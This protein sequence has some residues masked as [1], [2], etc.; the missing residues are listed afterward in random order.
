MGAVQNHFP[1]EFL[2]RLDETIIFNPLSRADMVSVV[3]IRLKELEARLKANKK[4]RLDV[5]AEAKDWLASAG[6][7]PQYGARPLN[8]VIQSEILFPLSRCVLDG[9]VR[10]TETAVIEADHVNNR[11]S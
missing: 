5:T 7:S 4:I 6:Y 1:P 3:E 9:S 11:V 8:R 10:E 2:N